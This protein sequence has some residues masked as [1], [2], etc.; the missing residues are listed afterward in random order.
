MGKTVG[1]VILA[2]ALVLSGFAICGKVGDVILTSDVMELAGEAKPRMVLANTY[3]TDG[4]SV[5]FHLWLVD[6][7]SRQVV[8]TGSFEVAMN[9]DIEGL[10]RGTSRF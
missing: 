8:S 9:Q 3:V 2:T 10:L 7:S 6:A 1:A 5:T 4:Q